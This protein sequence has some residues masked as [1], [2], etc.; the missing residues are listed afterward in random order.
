MPENPKSGPKGF[1]FAL[2]LAGAGA[3]TVLL[4]VL[5]LLASLM[6]H[7]VANRFF[8]GLPRREV[9]LENVSTPSNM[10]LLDRNWKAFS[11]SNGG[12]RTLFFTATGVDYQTG[13][14]W[15]STNPTVALLKTSRSVAQLA[16]SNSTI[17]YALI[18][19]SNV[20]WRLR[21]GCFE[22]SWHDPLEQS[23]RDLTDKMRGRPRSLNNSWTG[24]RY[25][26]VSGE[27]KQ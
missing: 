9:A 12:P 16:P 1:R 6:F 27:V 23:A 18:P 21:V 26:V 22:R 10:L 25:E 11:L 5:V 3:V 19:N 4:L 17:F 24:R 8:Y 14:G 7:R 15:V 13:V 20:I 2:G